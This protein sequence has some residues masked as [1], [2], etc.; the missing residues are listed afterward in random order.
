MKQHTK[1]IHHVN[2][3]SI[4]YPITELNIG[5]AERALA[6]T[7][8]RLSK[9]CY[10]PL[11]ACLYGAGT[12]ADGI[13]AAGIP[14]I[15]LG[16]QGKWDMRVAYRLF[17]L[18]RREGVQILHSYMFH[19]DVLGR[20][21]GKAAGVPIIISSRHNVEIGGPM[22]E[23]LN[24]GTANLADRTIAVSDQV[25]EVEIQRSGADPSKVATIYYGVD[26]EGFRGINPAKV[27]KL[28]RQFSIDMGTPIIGTIASFHKRKGHLHL[29]ES[30]PL[31][32]KRFPKAKVL[33]IGDGPLR[34]SIRRK[35][36]DRYL[37]SSVIFT[38]IRYDIP[39]LLSIFDVF[40][41]PSLWEGMPNVILEAMATG[42]PVVATHVGG[43]PE[44]VEDGVT[45]LLVPPR[46]PEALAE[47]IIALLQDRERAEAMGRAGR[48]RVE[49][50][51]GVERM[52][53]Q[54]EALYEELVREKMGLEW[55]EG[56]GWQPT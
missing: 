9:S 30:L 22:R 16:A 36:K 13:R 3:I 44:V 42:K 15:D 1:V 10:R 12:V 25:R 24:R 35:A 20:I 17:R 34:E 4:L 23:L 27:K 19:T 52:V 32:L 47:A 39:E 51:F 28:K 18:L 26:L 50:Y 45:G 41:L 33:L 49:K 56:K 31:V 48:A 21:V 40:V 37:S 7:V 43:V 8:T 5:G 38:G 46:D 11:V 2:Q 55:A 29:I 54:T 6:R 14:V 53:R